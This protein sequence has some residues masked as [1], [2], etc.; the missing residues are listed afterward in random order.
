MDRAALLEWIASRQAA[1][2]R[3]RQELR[4]AGANP[5]QSVAQMLALI[6]LWE[7]LH[8][9]PAPEDPVTAREDAAMYETWS[10]LRAAAR[11]R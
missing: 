10:R 2:A 11:R 6:A 1:E 9:W 7:R 4:E 3:E 5:E 8:G